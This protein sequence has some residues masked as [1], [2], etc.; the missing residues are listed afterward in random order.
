MR[1]SHGAARHAVVLT[2]AGAPSRMRDFE[3]ADAPQGRG[4]TE[5]TFDLSTE[6]SEE[7]E[8][9]I[10]LIEA[11][12][13]GELMRERRSRERL[14]E[15]DALLPSLASVGKTAL[16]LPQPALKIPFR[17]KSLH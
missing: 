11:D 8:E 3:D 1:C 15:M 2:K 16:P 4:Y 12:N 9:P 6:G 7:N 14:R 13:L 5:T 10:A 17:R